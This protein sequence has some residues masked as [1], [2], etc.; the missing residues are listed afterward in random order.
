MKHFNRTSNFEF[1]VVLSVWNQFYSPEQFLG[2]ARAGLRSF[3]IGNRR[4]PKD[5]TAGARDYFS[6]AWL[7]AARYLPSE[8]C[9]QAS[10]WSFDLFSGLHSIKAPLLW[11]FAPMNTRLIGKA[12]RQSMPV[13][14]DV[15]I[16]HQRLYKQI[17]ATENRKLGLPFSE[18]LVESW[19]RK[20]EWEYAHANWICAGSQ[21][22]KKTLVERGIPPDII[23]VNHYGVD[24]GRWSIAHERRMS[25]RDRMVFVYVAGVTPR[26]GIH[27]LVDAWRN[28]RLPDADLV[29]AGGTRASIESLC[30]SLPANIITP[31]RLNHEQMVDLY[32]RS[33]VYVLPSLLEGLA[34]S[35]IEAMS[36]GLPLLITE[37]TGLTDFAENGKEAWVVPSR[38]IEALSAQLKWCYDHPS[39]VRAAGDRAYCIGRKQTFESYGDRCAA[40][41]KSIN[42]GQNPR[43]LFSQR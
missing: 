21:Y 20:Y 18:G 12:N 5:A 39:E 42:S 33:D 16:G 41:V 31:G 29:L 4:R 32:G 30:G 35:G 6:V 24:A 13:V 11:A 36:A 28:A 34:R 10:M 19:V 27:Y 1:D 26:K 3:W 43:E 17:M 15:A 23:L 37:E 25:S 7:Y 8:F 2:F 22:V 38:N 14:L 9:R 40:I